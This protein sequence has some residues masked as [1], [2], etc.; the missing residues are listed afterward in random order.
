MT[1]SRRLC[2]SL[3]ASVVWITASCGG[4]TPPPAGPI[5]GQHHE[6]A[7]EPAPGETEAQQ[8]PEPE[9]ALPPEPE[10][11]VFELRN[12]GD[13]PLNFGVTKG[14]GPVIFAY[15]GKPPKA[16]AVILFES[17][18][19]A[20]CEAPPE[21]ICPVCPEPKDKREELAMA[22]L[23][24]AQP[25]TSIKVPWDGLVRVY[26]N[27]PGKKR[28]KCFRVAPPA[29]DSYTIKA[30]GLRVAREAGKASRPVCAETVVTLGPGPVDPQTITLSFAK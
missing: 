21:E 17:A 3:A 10:G 20:S 30:C 14:W 26:E 24:T 9:P 2:A 16:K 19:T 22:R 18:C 29:A 23:E 8:A 5:P 7:P 4:R 13:L 11:V 15:T 27:A 12:D 1:P 25:G 28:C 6:M